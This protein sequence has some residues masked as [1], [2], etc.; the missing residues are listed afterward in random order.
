MNQMADETTQSSTAE[1]TQQTTE[2]Q[3]GV[4]P[5]V[6]LIRG[7]ETQ[8]QNTETTEQTTQETSTEET[9]TETGV[10]EEYADFTLAEGLTMDEAATTSFKDFAK[11]AGLTQDQ[12]QKVL[13]Y[14]GQQLKER[15][16]APYRE[17]AATQEKWVQ[18]VKDDPTIGGTK[19]E[20]TLATANSIFVH[21]ELNP[22]IK[23]AEESQ[24]L[25]AAL[26]L[27]GAANNPQMVKL[28]ARMGAMLA[29]PGNLTGRPN[30]DVNTKDGDVQTMLDAMY[31]S[32]DKGASE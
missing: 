15:L 2:T 17:W 20:K 21:G 1:T 7:E 26:K 24:A 23:T 32:M 6:P 18:E 12:A 8:V 3:S 19:L 31:P 30:P 16:E 4:T 9:K 11:G 10:P 27:T 22:F 25:L 5:P 14:G 28:F 13:D 29:E